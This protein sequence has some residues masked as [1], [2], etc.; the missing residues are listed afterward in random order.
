[1]QTTQQQLIRIQRHEMTGY[2]IYNRLAKRVRHEKN[3]KVLERIAHHELNHYNILKKYSG[4]SVGPSKIK[5]SW[6]LLLVRLL[7]LTFALK[8]MERGEK[9]SDKVYAAI[10]SQI[11]EVEQILKDEELHEHELLDMLDEEA[12]NYMGSVVL[13][14]N[15]A[16][17]ELSGALAGFTFALQN[18]RVIAL[19]GLITGIAATFS[20]AASEFLSQRHEDG[21]TGE[22]LK[23]S[24]YTGVAYIGTVLLLVLPYFIFPNHFM[25]LGFM[26]G[27]VFLVVF[28]FNFYIAVAKDMPF[29]KRFAEMAI[30]STSVA[31]L[32]FGI[33]W[34]VRT[35]W[36]LDI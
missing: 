8:L 9:E 22:A 35:F 26:M 2:E 28:I 12:L 21:T 5:V 34:A 18:S 4:V 30:I 11:P 25:N 1:M 31:S 27:V 29:W 13:G 14:L 17:V 36:G 7:G 20:M 32:S 24:L 15:D 16:L 3:A 19:L 6:Y 10:R 23:S 33:G